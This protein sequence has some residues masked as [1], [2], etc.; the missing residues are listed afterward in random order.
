MN[1]IALQI[2]LLTFKCLQENF[3]VAGNV[4][5][6]I[7]LD[8]IG[9]AFFPF[10][11]HFI[12]LFL[13]RFIADLHCNPRVVLV[14]LRQLSEISE[15]MINRLRRRNQASNSHNFVVCALMSKS[16]HERSHDVVRFFSILE[17]LKF[18]PLAAHSLQRVNKMN[19][20]S[21]HLSLSSVNYFFY[22]LLGL[23]NVFFS[24]FFPFLLLLACMFGKFE[25]QAGTIILKK[26]AR[27]K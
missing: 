25:L 3:A 2:A 22:C 26:I 15:R 27:R 9:I 12:F 8:A 17:S 18:S 23:H 1:L 13:L 16:R 4:I 14:L 10:Y 5:S 19:V 24:L 6:T 21:N 20:N 11:R 7:I